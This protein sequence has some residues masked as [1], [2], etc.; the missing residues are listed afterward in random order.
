MNVGD[1]ATIGRAAKL[2]NGSMRVFH[3]A[4]TTEE[5]NKAGR[6]TN[7]PDGDYLFGGS[8]A[9]LRAVSLRKPAIEKEAR[10]RPQ[11]LTFGSG[12]T[13][14]ENAEE[15]N[16]WGAIGFCANP[17][18]ISFMKYLALL[19]VGASV[20]HGQQFNGTVFDLDSGRIQ[21]INGSISEDN[22]VA[23]MRQ[24]TIEGYRRMNAE[25]EV[26]IAN[27]RAEAEMANQ[28]RELREQTE[29]LRK[30]ANE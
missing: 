29:L 3:G 10:L 5:E 22:S 19:L 8:G 25:L 17:L 1:W 21:V 15:F 12:E 30:I 11:H 28:T 14:H 20:S 24:R 18:P 9:T 13:R 23:A 6:W 2:P 4:G 7:I 27:M 26:S 16:G